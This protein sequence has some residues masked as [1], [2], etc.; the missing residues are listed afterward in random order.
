MQ[1]SIVSDNKFKSIDY[2][3]NLIFILVAPQMGENIGAIARCMKNFGQKD[4]RIVSPRDGWP[5]EK[6]ISVATNAKDI[7]QNATVYDSLSNAIKDLSYLYATTATT[8]DMNKPI[9]LSNNLHQDIPNSGKIGLMV[10]RE[11]SGLTNEEIMHANKIITIP[12]SSEYSSLNISHAVSII[13]YE[14]FHKNFHFNFK[15]QDLAELKEVQ[16]LFD[17]LFEKLEAKN[18]FKVEHKKKIMKQNI[19]NM[20]M[21]INDFSKQDVQTLRGV[22]SNLFHRNNI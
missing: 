6:A 11:S 19:T 17:D 13:C 12:T 15:N 16:M 18:F 2:R 10:G 1:N 7:I 20:L 5:N 21:R 8:R 22:I 3:P 14:L 9:I 4:L